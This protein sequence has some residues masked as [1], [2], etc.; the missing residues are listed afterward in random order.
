MSFELEAWVRKQ[1]IGNPT[2]KYVLRELASCHNSETGLCFPSLDVLANG[3]EL[4]KNTVRTAIRFLVSEG[5]IRAN[6]IQNGNRVGRTEYSFPKYE[7]EGNPMVQN[8]IYQNLKHQE[9]HH[10][11]SE[12]APSNCE[13]TTNDVSN[14]DISNPDISNS[15]LMMVQNLHPNKEYVIKNIST[16]TSLSTRTEE[17]MPHS[18]PDYLLEV[19]LEEYDV[20]QAM[21]ELDGLPPIDFEP[22]DS[23]G[24]KAKRIPKP[25]NRLPDCPYEAIVDLYHKHCPELP[26]VQSITEKRKSNI[27]ARWALVAKE[28]KTRETKELLDFFDTFFKSVSES[29]FLS[30]RLPPSPG[31]T[32]PFKAN[33]DWL[34]NPQNFV[35]C[36]EGY[37]I[38]R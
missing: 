11:G 2:A 1:R 20:A 22:E 29:D 14:S 36:I 35:K 4:S 23:D 9:L 16:T 3:L 33:L 12:I 18:V 25:K 15:D 38:N 19:P 10:D 32:T 26:Y 13:T 34:M 30:G 8:L 27:K 31:R 37:Y 17:V 5:W 24:K 6:A 21:A 28:N 7:K